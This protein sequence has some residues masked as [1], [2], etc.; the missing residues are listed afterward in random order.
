MFTAGGLTWSFA[1]QI[2]LPIFTAGQNQGNLDLAKVQKLTQVAQYEQTIQTAFREV[3]DAL[4]GR[5]TYVDQVAS[6]QQLV[7]AAADSLRLSL[8]RFRGGVDAFL[9]VLQA[10]P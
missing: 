9:P 3:S 5:Q 6:Q 1:P 7:D 8:L 4:A 2:N 10:Q